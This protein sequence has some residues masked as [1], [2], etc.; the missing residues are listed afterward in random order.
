MSQVGNQ[1]SLRAGVNAQ[2]KFG[3][4]GVPTKEEIAANV[5]KFDD[6]LARAK[7]K[8][9]TSQLSDGSSNALHNPSAVDLVSSRPQDEGGDDN[10]LGVTL[11]EQFKFNLDMIASKTQQMKMRKQGEPIPAQFQDDMK[12]IA[13]GRKFT[14]EEVNIKVKAFASYSAS[15]QYTAKGADN[16]E[17]KM[18]A[19]MKM[20]F[21]MMAQVKIVKTY[22]NESSIDALVDGMRSL[23]EE[24]H[25]HAKHL[26]QKHEDFFANMLEQKPVTIGDADAPIQVPT[27]DISAGIRETVKMR[28]AMSLEYS[29][30]VRNVVSKL[31]PSLQ[32]DIRSLADS[33]NEIDDEMSEEELEAMEAERLAEEAAEDEAK[34][35]ELSAE[36]RR[37]AQQAAVTEVIES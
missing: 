34:V 13:K 32:E 15:M 5:E 23:E 12:D 33:N 18:H 31:N 17:V 26:K 3:K 22:Q 30:S 4:Q 1:D 16:E 7:A 35:A 21:A 25:P 27:N 2:N 19:Y 11:N 28:F 9:K 10:S 6:V 37:A 36:E 14:T 24:E 20:E 29:S 8:T